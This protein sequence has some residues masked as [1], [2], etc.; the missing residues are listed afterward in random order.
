MCQASG[1]AAVA[2]FQE[3][4]HLQQQLDLLKQCQSLRT[5]LAKLTE[6]KQ[7]RDQRLVTVS[8]KP[9]NLVRPPVVCSLIYIVFMLRFGV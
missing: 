8:N 2:A 9:C 1:A 3:M 6:M 5:E 4:Q 7:L